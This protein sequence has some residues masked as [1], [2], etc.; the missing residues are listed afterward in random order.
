ML[1]LGVEFGSRHPHL[2]SMPLALAAIDALPPSRRDSDAHHQL[3]AEIERALTALPTAAPPEAHP[4]TIP[5]WWLLVAGLAV[6]AL[7]ITWVRSR[8][9][10]RAEGT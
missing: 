7:G 8:S 10:K 1:L 2:L 6:I 3:R 9:A 4:P 5:T